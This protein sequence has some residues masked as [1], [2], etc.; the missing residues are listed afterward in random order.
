MDAQRFSKVAESLRQYRRAELKDFESDLGGRA[1]DKLYVDALPGEAVLTS[2]MS[3]STTFLLGRKGTGKSTV[4]A[5]AQ[6]VMRERKNL[7][8]VYLDVKSICDVLGASENIDTSPGELKI[9]KYA[10]QAHMVRKSM[11]GKILS[12]LLKEVGVACDSLSLWDRW[13]GH[14]KQLN[15]LKE[16]LAKLAD[17]VKDAKL[18]KHELPVLQNISKQL[19]AKKHVQNSITRTAKGAASGNI[20]LKGASGKIDVESSQAD[21]DNVLDDSDTYEEYSDVVIKSFPFDEIIEN[22]QTLL[23]EAS[24]ARLVV[25]FDDFSELRLIDQRLFVDVILSPL[26]NSSKESIK[27]KIAGYPGRVYYGRIDPGKTDTVSLDFSELYE[28][29]EVQE[30]EKAASDYASRLIQT[31]FSAFDLSVENYFDTSAAPLEDYMA[32]L[33]R[34]SF[35]VPRIMGYILHQCFLDKVSRGQK[36]TQAAIRLAVRKYYEGTVSKYFDRLNKYALEP[37]DNKLDRHNQKMLLDY[38]VREV[39]QVRRRIVDNEVGGKY[40]SELGSNPPVSH[41]MVSPELEHIFRSLES[42]FFLSR[43]KNTRDKE[44]KQG[45]VYALFMGLTESERL[46]WGYPDGRSFRNYFV[47]RCFEYSRA[48]HEFLS[49]SQTIK[50]GKCEFCHPMEDLENI[51]RYKWRCPEC[52][53]GVCAIQNISDEFKIEVEKLNKE[54]MLEPVELEIIS[55]LKDEKREMRAGEIATLIDVTHQLVG[56]RTSKLSELGLINKSRGDEDGKM[57]SALTERCEKTYFDD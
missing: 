19:R 28:A 39:K 22:I 45:I 49:S 25:F 47:Q 12:E 10:Y 43:Y 40:F 14:K 53:E 27:L 56:R 17:K 9:S 52:M 37:F 3:G 44:G 29:G 48:V 46:S 35:N 34:S 57:R 30:M 5:K 21:F 7:I 54:I 55:T 8:S 42:N 51:K 23:A 50:C 32:L 6:S 38:V 18:E 24:L 16:S 13:N 4:F 1:V 20:D 33:F 31:R 41:F 36:I 26:N 2:V 11:L 15:E